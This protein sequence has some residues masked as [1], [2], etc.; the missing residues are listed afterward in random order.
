MART[1]KQAQ[2]RQSE[3]AQKSAAVN[4]SGGSRVG[5]TCGAS[6]GGDEAR[7]ASGSERARRAER[8]EAAARQ[9]TGTTAN[10]ADDLRHQTATEADVDEDGHSGNVHMTPA[11]GG[12]VSENYYTSLDGWE[13]DT[14]EGDS[15][16]GPSE[17]PSIKSPLKPRR[18]KQ[19]GRQTQRDVSNRQSI[20]QQVRPE[21][22]ERRKTKSESRADAGGSKGSAPSQTRR[23]GKKI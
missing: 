11:A 16:G 10:R 2:A 17:A 8:R 4:D 18:E 9:R 12:A 6:E 13:E 3:S 5:T 20:G 1:K 14:G 15:D 23:G 19:G 22:K 21:S 7:S